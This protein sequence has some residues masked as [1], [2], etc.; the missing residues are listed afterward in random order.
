MTLDFVDMRR[1]SDRGIFDGEPDREILV[2]KDV[3]T[4][5]IGALPTRDRSTESVV[6]CIKKFAGNKRSN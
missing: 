1:A 6:D 2:M 4:K 3:A 5:M